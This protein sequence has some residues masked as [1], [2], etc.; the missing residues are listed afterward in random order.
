VQVK[1]MVL[2][3]SKIKALGFEPKFD[4]KSIVDMLIENS[5]KE[6]IHE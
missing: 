4:M 6:N 2:D 1:N 3:V 5:P